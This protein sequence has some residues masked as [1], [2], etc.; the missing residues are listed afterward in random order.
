M[1]KTKIKNYLFR[2]FTQ[3]LGIVVGKKRRDEILK[4]FSIRRNSKLVRKFGPEVLC[5]FSEIVKRNGAHF[6]LFFGTLLGA[7]RDGGFIKHDDDIDIGMFYDEISD[8]IIDDMIKNGFKCLG[9]I[10]DKDYS[11]GYQVAFDYKGLKFDIYSFQRNISNNTVTVFSPLPFNYSSWESLEREDIYDEL[12]IIFN[13][14]EELEKINFEG[15]QVFIPSN[16]DDILKVLYGANYLIPIVN[17]KPEED[18][19]PRKVHEDPHKH[20]ACK[21]SYEVFKMFRKAQ[22]I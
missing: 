13:S 12:H 1:L 7:Y 5:V 18:I 14:W 16:S 2:R 21:M 8:S 15:A 10:V 19:S 4:R 20:Y 11:G 3:V 17:Y 6:W 22:L 9:V